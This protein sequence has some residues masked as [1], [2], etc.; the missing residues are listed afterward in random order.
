MLFWAVENPPPANYLLISGDRDFS[1]ALHQLR[2]RKY[3]ILL[4]QPANVSQALVAAAKSV[5]LWTSLLIGGSPLPENPHLHGASSGNRSTVET[6]SSSAPDSTQ[7]A[8]SNQKNHSN[9]RADNR[10]KGKQ[11]RRMQ[12]QQNASIPRTTSNGSQEGQQSNGSSGASS[13]KWKNGMKQPNP[14]STSTKSG[15]RTQ[16]SAQNSSRPSSSLPQSSPQILPESN[17]PNSSN[18]PQSGYVQPRPDISWSN[19]NNFPNHHQTQYSQSPRPSDLLPPQTNLQPRNLVESNSIYNSYPSSGTYDPSFSTT[20]TTGP[21]GLPFTELP[22]R[23]GGP[24]FPPPPT[25]PHGPPFTSLPDMSRLSVTEYPNGVHQNVPPFYHNNMHISDTMDNNTSNN[26]SW[27][28]PGCPAPSNLVQGMIGFILRALHALKTDK[29]APTEHN[30]A[31]CIH[32]GEINMPTFNV[33]M[34]LDYA[35]EHQ[36]VLVHKLNNLPL[37]VGKNDTLWKCINIVDSNAKHPKAKFDA[38]LKF[39]SSTDGR[40]AILSSKCRYYAILT[41]HSCLIIHFVAVNY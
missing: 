19:G 32:Y 18:G 33:R 14:V 5:W 40:N 8:D 10:I 13:P 39:L 35:I 11:S 20:P 17:R 31:D 2:M 28:T 9:G 36:V 30:I 38:V 12:N 29:I 27:G 24:P 4:A 15:P 21:N 7:P 23:P 6:P 26:V 25:L 41:F 37:Y 34:A 22:G 3:N 16:E 1:N